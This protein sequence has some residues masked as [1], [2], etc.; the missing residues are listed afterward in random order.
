[1][2][3]PEGWRSVKMSD[4]L[5]GHVIDKLIPIMNRIQQGRLDLSAG[6]KQILALL[7]P[8]KAE[9]EAKGVLDEYLS[10][11]LVNA[12]VNWPGRDLSDCLMN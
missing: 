1:M 4:L 2:A 3:L 8:L 10:W 11:W 7:T 6:R 9:L 12:A 5:P